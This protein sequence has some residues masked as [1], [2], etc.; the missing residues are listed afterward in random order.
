MLAYF[1]REFGERATNGDPNQF[2]IL[3]D[4]IKEVEQKLELQKT[5]KQGNSTVETDS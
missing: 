3:T 4:K 5:K 1:E 2:N